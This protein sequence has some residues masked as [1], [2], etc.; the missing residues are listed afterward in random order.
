M[1]NGQGCV[2]FCN[3]FMDDLRQRLQQK[4]NSFKEK[5]KGK[6]A[7]QD[8]QQNINPIK[9]LSKRASRKQAVIE[10]KRAKEAAKQQQQNAD[11]QQQ[12]MKQKNPKPPLITSKVVDGTSSDEAS[13]KR[14][15]LPKDPKQALEKLQKQKQALDL[16]PIE[17]QPKVLQDRAWAK[18]F[19][20]A[21]GLPVQDDEQRLKK[22]L[23]RKASTKVKRTS[24]WEMRIKRQTRTK[25]QKQKIRQ[26]HIQTRKEQVKEHR[27]T[28]QKRAIK[29]RQ[30]VRDEKNGTAPIASKKKAPKYFECSL[31]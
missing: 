22:A 9:K 21:R 27:V 6:T 5:R 17:K 3:I 15:V 16:L 24:S 4:L 29:K 31:E 19:L 13:R 11:S 12:T 8:V 26:E 10:A 23:K 20:R 18:A 25:E 28:K 7:T 14:Y 1:A 30:R 2:I